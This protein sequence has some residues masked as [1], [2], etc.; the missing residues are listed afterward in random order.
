MTFKELANKTHF[1]YKDH[2]GEYFAWYKVSFATARKVTT[3]GLVYG[4]P[5]VFNGLETVEVSA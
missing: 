2:S 1:L 3:L 4:D 5:V